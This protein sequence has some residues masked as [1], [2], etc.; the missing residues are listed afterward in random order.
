MA[1]RTGNRYQ[2]S[3][4]RQ[5]YVYGNAVAQPAY[6][7]RKQAGS[8][9]RKSKPVS[10]QVRRNRRQ[11]LRVNKA[12]VVFMAV[13]AVLALVVCV[14]YVQLQSELTKRSQNITALQEELA[15]AKEENTTKY[16]VVMDSVN[17][18]QVREKAINEL[19]MTYAD[20]SQIVEYDNPSGDYAEQYEDIPKDGVVASAKDVQN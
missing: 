11:S 14:N 12:Y 4:A 15:A 17:L 3:T 6:E 9:E 18:E 19:G 10:V 20:D 13:A 7:P 1:G 2:S 5:S 8:Q 16:N